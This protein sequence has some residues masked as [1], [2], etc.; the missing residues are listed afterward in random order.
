[1]YYVHN[2]SLVEI[3]LCH[4]SKNMLIKLDHKA[5]AIKN[6]QLYVFRYGSRYNAGEDVRSE[7]KNKPFQFAHKIAYILL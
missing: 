5:N 2:C 6:I 3:Y 1:M 7:K 4:I